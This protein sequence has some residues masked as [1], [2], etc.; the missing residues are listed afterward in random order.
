MPRILP[1]SLPDPPGSLPDHACDLAPSGI[2]G[3]CRRFTT[4]PLPRLTATLGMTRSTTRIQLVDVLT[5]RTRSGSA[6]GERLQ[7]MMTR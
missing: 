4:I 1:G 3:K 6:G 2:R 7:I 5:L